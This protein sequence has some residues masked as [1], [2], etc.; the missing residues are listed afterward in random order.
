V[1][2]HG[3]IALA[4]LVAAAALFISRRLPLEA[5]AIAIPLALFLTG[6]VPDAEVALSGFGNQAVIALAAVFVLGAA[7]QESG[8]AELLARRVERMGA[9][10]EGRLVLVVCLAV[11]LMSAFM[12]NAAAVAVMLPGIVALAQRSSVPVSRLML[13]TSFAAVLGGNLTLIATAPN[14]LLSEHLRATT[15][16]GFHMFDF[17]VV[18][19]PIA[20]VGAL[21]LA[22]PGR[23]L[24]PRAPTRERFTRGGL[25]GRLAHEYGLA[26]NLTR[27]RVEEG[28]LL[29]GKAMFEL[30]LADRYDVVV[31]LIGRRAGLGLHWH[32]PT[33]DLVLQV[34]DDLY[35]EGE[36]ENLWQL[37]EEQQTRIGLT[38]AHHVEAVLDQG[39]RLAE[40]LV[41]PHSAAVGKTLHEVG[42]RRQYRVSV[43]TV[44]RGDD[45]LAAGI[46]TTPL[47]M[48][49]TLLVTG[50]ASAVRRLRESPDFVVLSGDDG[51]RDVRKAPLA[52][53]LLALALLPPV[54]DLAPLAISALL[55][56]LLTVLSGCVSAKEAARAIDWRVLALVV[57][58]LPLGHAL[59][60]HGVATHAAHGLLWLTAG[61]GEPAALACLFAAAATVTMASSNA[62][63]AVILAP[64][65]TAV[66]A[67]LGLPV[68]TPLLA[69]AYGCG[70]AFLMPY[71]NQCHLMVLAPGGYRLRDFLKVG[72]LMSL[73]VAA[74]AIGGLALLL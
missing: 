20:L 64:V 5:T 3:W 42:F 55:A 31:V 67:T 63:A 24:L 73:V 22:G 47:E 35:M 53:A 23:R 57:G 69:V 14:L 11:V 46:S 58:T 36:T 51:G 25:P 1:T 56:A 59:A 19:L 6:T 54:L 15:G 43:L 50:S 37:A 9:G 68:T 13:P 17:A 65:A 26:E 30:R 72:A 60:V 41:G 52:L 38:G 61:L 70:C 10:S 32:V 4:I 49:D 62:A 48:G 21:T 40:V 33:S 16:S 71:S 28:S 66:G 74:V 39:I 18:G 45:K 44:W 34:G 7:L 27:L 8:V 29:A 12:P 2:L